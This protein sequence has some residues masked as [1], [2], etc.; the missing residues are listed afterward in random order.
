MIWVMI[1]LMIIALAMAMSMP[2][3][4][5]VGPAALTDGDVPLAEDGR[6][7]CVVFGE[8]VI[9]DNNVLNYGAITTTPIKSDGG[10]K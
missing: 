1:I 10:G 8:C 5:S 2:G 9:S 3:P 7:M 4:Q 6:D